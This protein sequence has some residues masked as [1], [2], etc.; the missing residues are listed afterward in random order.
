MGGLSNEI[1]LA[2]SLH[3]FSLGQYTRD[4]LFIYGKCSFLG[5]GDR[6]DMYRVYSTMANTKKKRVSGKPDNGNRSGICL[7]S[8]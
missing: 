4:M 5:L 3:T 7:N 1:D 2:E 8:K 6:F